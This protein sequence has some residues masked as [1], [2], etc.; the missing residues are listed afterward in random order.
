MFLYS[1][2]R[3]LRPE[4]VIEIGVSKGF[5]TEWFAAALAD[6]D[7]GEL[8]S[9]DDWSE[10][11]GGRADGPAP[12]LTRIQ[13]LG[14]KERVKFVSSDSVLWLSEQKPNSAH[15]VWIDGDHSY[16]GCKRDLVAGWRVCCGT[17]AVHD[18]QNA[19]VGANVR[20]A[21]RDLCLDGCWIDGARGIWIGK[22]ERGRPA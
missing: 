15:L 14:L 19:S 4:R 18:T 12:A 8:I 21:I 9:V 1:L 3:L 11:H 17:M 20:A 16:Q 6:N 5:V 10:T 7:F 22:K 13:D 2:V